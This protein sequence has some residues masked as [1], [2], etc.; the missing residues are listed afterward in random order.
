MKKY[1][2][3]RLFI[4]ITR[5]CNLE[6]PH[7]MRGNAQELT[8]TP[9]IINTLFSQVTE[10]SDLS[11]SGGETMLELDT[12]EYLVKAIDKHNVKVGRI[13]FVTN[14]TILNERVI[15]ILSDFTTNNSERIAEFAISDDDFHSSR[16]HAKEAYE[17]Y[18]AL[19]NGKIRIILNSERGEVNKI[20]KSKEYSL[21]HSGRALGFIANNRTFNG[22]SVVS[23]VTENDIRPHRIK[24][25]NNTIHCVLQL[26][27]N[28]NIGFDANVSY[29]NADNLSFGN[30]LQDSL[31]DILTRHNASCVYLC[32]ETYNE[33]LYYN[34]AFLQAFKKDVPEIRR[35]M[36]RLHAQTRI[37][38]FDLVWQL[39]KWALERYPNIG[40]EKIISCTVLDN[41]FFF[42]KVKALMVKRMPDEKLQF[43]PRV[44]RLAQLA[45]KEVLEY[46]MVYQFEKYYSNKYPEATEKQ[47]HE[48]SI[49]NSMYK[50]V[51][52][53][54]L[55][56][57][58]EAVFDG[59]GAER[60]F[61]N[62]D[63]WIEQTEFKTDDF[64]CCG[65][66][67]D[68]LTPRDDEEEAQNNE[69]DTQE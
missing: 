8:I 54:T 49:L 20:K 67:P 32:D 42:E 56:D 2:F 62:L 4:E 3:L 16:E 48:L 43:N 24:I 35:E 17:F 34:V 57:L 66:I 65:L 14:G 30:I 69:S 15:Q 37:K 19:A 1:K 47:I 29:G 26:S 22:L 27:A 52:S 46:K 50:F 41:D 51:M 61:E 23:R 63:H 6:C 64:D 9:E 31:H 28:G 18:T 10:I 33:M 7:C 45:P 38:Q 55:D 60:Y 53:M 36:D 68:T 11:L 12:F 39:R 59:N 25:E 21:I 58:I 5:K 13:S 40:I 44:K